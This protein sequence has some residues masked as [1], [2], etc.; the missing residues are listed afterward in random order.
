MAAGDLYVSAEMHWVIEV[1]E[2]VGMPGS[3][4]CLY[5]CDEHIPVDLVGEGCYKMR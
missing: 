3:A 4:Q 1:D 5:K 2:L